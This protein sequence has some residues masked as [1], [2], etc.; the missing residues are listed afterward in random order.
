MR[1]LEKN[2]KREWEFELRMRTAMKEHMG[3]I[4]GREREIGL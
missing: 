3:M 4:A 2:R 1:W